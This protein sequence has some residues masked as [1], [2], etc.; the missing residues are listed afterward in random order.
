L[1]LINIIIEEY[2]N[3]FKFRFTK[4]TNLKDLF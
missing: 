1:G 3:D 4:L 2:L